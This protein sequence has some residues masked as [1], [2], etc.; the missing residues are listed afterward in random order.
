MPAWKWRRSLKRDKFESIKCSSFIIIFFLLV[1]R[2]KQD[3]LP[4]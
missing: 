3:Q 1:G 4:F 2:Q